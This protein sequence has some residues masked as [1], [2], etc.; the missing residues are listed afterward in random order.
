[1]VA[2]AILQIGTASAA[3]KEFTIADHPIDPDIYRRYVQEKF[4]P[5]RPEMSDLELAQKLNL[6]RPEMA[7]VKAAVKKK[8][9]KALRKALGI[10]LDSKVKPRKIKP[11]KKPLSKGVRE[12]AAVWLADEHTF[13]DK[14]YK[15]G[16]RI[17][18]WVSV[19][20]GAESF[21]YQPYY[22]GWYLW[23]G[24]LSR[25]YTRSG[26][27]RY[28][29]R[30]L[31]FTRSFYHTARPPMR[32][33]YCDW[34][35]G[36]FKAAWHSL[37]TATRTRYLLTTYRTIGGS[38]GC[39][40]AD[41]VMFL[42][43]IWE[44]SDYVK[45]LLDKHRAHNFETSV[46]NALMDAAAAFPEFRDAP[47]WIERV[48]ES[49]LL[50]MRDC[51][52]DDGGA[53]ERTTYHFMYL[54]HYIATY[55][56]MLDAGL[57][58]P[59]EVKQTLARMHEWAMWVLAPNGDYP[60]FG[61][62]RLGSKLSA[63]RTGAELFAD[64]ADFAYVATGGKKGTP[65]PRVARVLPH[66]GFLTMRS[67]W[68]PDALFMALNYNGSPKGTDG[69][70]DLPSF[71]I[72]SHGIAWMTNAGMTTAGYTH[73]ELRDFG[74]RTIGQNTVLVDNTSQGRHDMGGRLE[75]WASLPATGPGFTYAAAISNAYRR[76][77]KGVVH[78]RAV[79][80]VRP[81]YWLML[82]QLTGDG[83][84]HDYE[85][86]GHFQPT[87]LTINPKTKAIA[88]D[89]QKGKRFWM[90]PL[91]PKSFT[92]EETTGPMA[93]A[94]GNAPQPYY[95]GR[96]MAPFIK[97]KKLGQKGPAA[98]ATIFCPADAEGDAPLAES[99]AVR[100]GRRVLPMTEAVGCRMRMGGSDDLLV[101]AK[102]S[103]MREYGRGLRTDAEAAFVRRRDGRVTEIGL[104]EGRQVIYGGKTL[105][106]VG[107]DVDAAHVRFG[108]DI[109]EISA[110]GSGVVSLGT[111]SVDQVRLNGEI[112][113]ARRT[114][115]RLNVR[116]GKGGRLIVGKPTYASDSLSLC[117]AIGLPPE[118]AK[119]VRGTDSIVASSLTSLPA[120]AKVECRERGSDV[121]SRYVNPEPTRRHRFVLSNLEFG[122]QY[123]LRITHHGVGGQIGKL[124]TAFTDPECARAKRKEKLG[125]VAYYSFDEGKGAVVR[126]RSGKGNHGEIRGG[127]K[128]VQ[129]GK[130]YALRFDGQN[131]YV[132]CGKRASLDIGTE[133]SVALWCYVESPQGGLVNRS[134]GGGWPDQRLVIVVRPENRILS[135]LADGKQ[136]QVIYYGKAELNCWVHLAMTWDR[137][138]VTIYR[139]GRSIWS[140]RREVTPKARGI[141]LK[142]G[143]SQG[144]GKQFFHGLIDEVRIYSRA[145]SEAEVRYHYCTTRPD[146]DTSGGNAR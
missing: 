10:Y 100:M 46:T 6:N 59:D 30:I 49:L 2:I 41:R 40:D 96:K 63:I 130:G 71:G 135:A 58:P 127:A 25:A 109:A 32:D 26:D 101:L 120:D 3:E 78:R 11:S 146:N 134:S 145:L 112:V 138:D 66:T 34:H 39:T 139:N 74:M 85:W 104:V 38:P 123:D 122:E 55:K 48:K 143:W 8:N 107:P 88:T 102:S 79:L 4:V 86:L 68:S 94:K 13:L 90:L 140:G 24:P 92:L 31:T 56:K 15:L 89:A 132:D 91:Q 35:G 65:P 115:D 99:L 7:G 70:E 117:K 47:A 142:L 17:N 12:E 62:G 119:G 93:T 97:L 116:A 14:K 28:A 22:A 33:G 16:E 57:S 133:G 43:M 82:D 37:S 54:N 76:I 137:D 131:D 87:R 141:P 129:R 125:L 1:M 44:H 51:I 64:R 111:L 60:I 110:H 108:D 98:Y 83:K 52:L 20:P 124:Q 136:R 27:R 113:E 18:W 144:F 36:S 95:S 72:W 73:E 75:S 69:Y 77:G 29:D 45:R 23:F 42:K 103:G 19:R 128:R 53:F 67:D 121:W 126:D 9:V 50:N 105:L 61:H 106:E 5:P 118:R 80:F 114:K 81:A 21:Y 84:R